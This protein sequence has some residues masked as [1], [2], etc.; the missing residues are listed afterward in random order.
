MTNTA[1]ETTPAANHTTK[2]Q[3]ISMLSTL[4]LALDIRAT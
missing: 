2:I 1:A 4:R 3:R